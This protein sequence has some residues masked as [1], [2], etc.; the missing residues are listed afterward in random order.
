MHTLPTFRNHRVKLPSA[1]LYTVRRRI[2]LTIFFFNLCNYFSVM[3]STHG[4]RQLLAG[5]DGRIYVSP[6]VIMESPNRIITSETSRLQISFFHFSAFLCYNAKAHW[7]RTARNFYLYFA[8]SQV[9]Q[10]TKI[11]CRAVNLAHGQF[12]RNFFHN[13]EIYIFFVMAC[14]TA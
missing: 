13:M 9:Y 6:K 10:F 5:L 1:S 3:T 7:Q 12:F 11:P 8:K 14:V 2:C 4:F